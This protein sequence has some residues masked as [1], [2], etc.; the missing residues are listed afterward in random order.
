MLEPFEVT[1]DEIGA[2]WPAILAVAS[3]CRE[4][5]IDFFVIGA[6][7][8]DLH[9][10]IIYGVDL[11]RAT[12]DLDIGIAVRGWEEFNS[13]VSH[14]E[15]V[16]GFKRDRMEHRVVKGSL[17]VDV[18]PFGN[19]AD[20]A[21]RIQWPK[22]DK[23]MS[24]LGYVEAFDGAVRF[25]IRD[26][27]IVRVASLAGIVVLKLIAWGGRPEQRRQD[28]IDLCTI[29]KNYDEVVA[30]D[31]YEKHDDVLD[32]DFDA[33]YAHARILGRD[34]APLLRSEEL[35]DRILAILDQ[36]LADEYD[37]PLADA[38]GRDCYRE[39]AVRIR[40]LQS[41]RQGIVERLWK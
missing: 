14:F 16:L 25:D 1:K 24:V 20:E 11:L 9:L 30:L 10:K 29:M 7:A 37:S 12:G 8:R 27:P 13:L 18:I 40:C 2:M 41:L 19:I 32:D 34:V 35:R 22:G 28:P 4:L 23:V 17:V 6:A 38:M 3:A 5:R 26:G 33:R 21:A 15:D 39:R 36:N 31:L